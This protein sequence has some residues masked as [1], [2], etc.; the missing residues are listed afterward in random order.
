M[1]RTIVLGM[2]VIAAVAAGAVTQSSA[3][4]GDSPWQLRVGVH[5]VRP[6]SGNGRV[7]GADLEVGGSVRPT[8]NVDYYVTPHLAVDLLASLPFH[9]DILLNGSKVGSAKQLPPTLSLQYHFFPAGPVDLFA[10]AGVNYTRFFSEKLGSGSD[11]ALSSSW[12]AAV[13]GG[14]DYRLIDGWSVGAD[15]R[16]MTLRTDVYSGGTKLGTAK[17]DPIAVGVTLARRF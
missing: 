3:A 8:F 5:D 15:L 14:I 17:I 10:G 4:S 1:A 6:K 7:A 12:G 9:H 11:L 16:W 13:Q 2:M